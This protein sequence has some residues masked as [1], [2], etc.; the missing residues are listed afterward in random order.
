MNRIKSIDVT[1]GFVMVIMALDH[2]RD[3]MNTT[4][5]TM[6]PTNL[7]TT[8]TLLFFTR[9]ITHLCAPAFVFLSGVSAFISFWRAENKSEI[10]KFLLTRGIWLIVLEFS[11]VNFALWF[12]IHFRLELFEVIAAIG[13]GFIILSLLL[14]LPSRIIGITGIIIIFCH[15]MLQGIALPSNSAA[16]FIFSVLFRP[17]LIQLSTDLSFFTAYPVIPWLGIML[18]GFSCGEFFKM[19]QENRMKI[20]LK[21]GVAMIIVFAAIRF[22][23]Y[24]GDPSKWSVQKSP[25]FTFLSF[26]NLTKYPPS[27]L[28]SLLFIGITL[29]VLFISEK[30]TGKFTEFLSVYGKVP[31]FYFVVHLYVIHAIMFLILFIQGFTSNVFVFG[32]FKNG[33]PEAGGG[34][35]LALI[36]LIW[37]GVVILLYPLC[38]WY[39]KMKSGH[40]YKLLRYL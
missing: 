31:L 17:N 20:F 4:S 15:N 37:I 25:L 9:W 21:A 14:S 35:G 29:L 27:L 32:V 11:L 24:Y 38:R 33:R 40:R 10:R 18:T 23:N 39:G 8:T 22:I 30:I 3:F 7:Q 19:P 5:M 1:R 26:I 12:D 13:S 28:F 2:V 6:D 34:V 16:A 36:Y